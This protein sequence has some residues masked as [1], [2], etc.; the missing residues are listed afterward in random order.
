MKKKLVHSMDGKK[1]YKEKIV[2]AN[3]TLHSEK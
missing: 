1:N 2:S 3:G